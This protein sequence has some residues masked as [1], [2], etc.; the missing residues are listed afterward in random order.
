MINNFNEEQKNKKVSLSK[1]KNK[2]SSRNKLINN[3]LISEN[4]RYKRNTKEYNNLLIKINSYNLKSNSLKK[5]KVINTK[6]IL[7]NQ[8]F[9]SN[10]NI[11]NTNLPIS[12][13]EMLKKINYNINNSKKERNLSI[14]SVKSE[15]EEKNKLEEKYINKLSCELI[16]PSNKKNIDKKKMVHKKIKNR[17][18]SPLEDGLSSLTFNNNFSIPKKFNSNIKDSSQIIKVNLIEN[19]KNKK[20]IKKESSYAISN[21]NTNSNTNSRNITNYINDNK[22]YK[23]T[24]FDINNYNN[25]IKEILNVKEHIS[26]LKEQLKGENNICNLTYSN[27]I[28]TKRNKKKINICQKPITTRN[29][30]KF[31]YLKTS[32]TILK[33]Q[34]NTISDIKIDNIKSN[35]KLIIHPNKI[36]QNINNISQLSKDSK[37][38]SLS[39]K[40]FCDNHITTLKNLFSP[41]RSYKYYIKTNSK[42]NISNRN[43]KSNGINSQKS[44]IGINN[45][46]IS[47]ISKRK[48]IDKKSIFSHLMVKDN[49]K[50]KINKKKLLNITGKCTNSNNKNSNKNENIDKKALQSIIK[51]KDNIPFSSI[52]I[53]QKYIHKNKNILKFQLIKNKHYNSFDMK[54][55]NEN[56]IFRII[57]S[58]S[59]ILPSLYKK[60]I[61][62]KN[63]NEIRK[64]IDKIGIIS[65]PGET[66]FGKVKINQ[67]NYF[68]YDLIN[69]YKYIG[70]CDGHG[71]FGHYVSKFIKN[72]LPKKLNSQLKNLLILKK[73]INYFHQNKN[74]KNKNIEF[75]N[76]KEI[77]INSYLLTNNKLLTKN[78]IN[79]L[80]LKLSGSTC[81]SILIDNKNLCKLYVSNTGDSRALIIK[82][83]KRKFWTCQQLSRDHKPIEKDESS[84]IYKSGGEIQ[85]IEDQYGG[86]AGPL[87]VWAKNEIGPGLA[88]TRSFG[89]ILGASIGIICLPE[90]SEYK[91]KQEDRVI[92][93]ASD[94]LWEYISN[95]EVTNIVK[96]S[97]IKNESDKIVNQLYKESYKKWKNKDK[98]IDD[99]TI[100][101]II[102]KSE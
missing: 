75:K 42:K 78:N 46:N 36:K 63:T 44:C 31:I 53:K 86:W 51:I 41:R 14:I 8:R 19:K 97:F 80:N 89:D 52:S 65:K 56:N 83:V 25:D 101:C 59:R 22:I 55:S 32:Q 77:L 91:I 54:L 69:N 24:V 74:K 7:N 11:F 20:V 76:L 61:K 23:N 40:K 90:I 29:E 87:R 17:N 37:R 100:I 62:E 85:K 60:I 21:S 58:K 12:Q 73:I 10:K 57:S 27:K 94:G 68:C 88:M 72:F 28:K 33:T 18:L 66:I 9:N 43:K 81:V 1:E 38:S 84:R 16:L 5:K 79:N 39:K 3:Y 99:I 49:Y 15:S 2:T 82:E 50:N 6:K 64:V 98:V 47:K 48:S 45:E 4:K 71:D 102:L 67:D 26:L 95:K 96:N 35:K 92:I 30:K 93:I 13:K 34:I 70:V